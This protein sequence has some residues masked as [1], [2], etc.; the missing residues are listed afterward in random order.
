MAV[1]RGEQSTATVVA[2]GRE[3]LGEQARA[4]DAFGDWQM[5]RIVLA[6]V[7][8]EP[9]ERGRERTGWIAGARQQQ[10]GALVGERLVIGADGR[11]TD[12]APRLDVN[13]LVRED[14]RE[15]GLGIEVCD[16]VDADLDLVADHLTGVAPVEQDIGWLAQR[17]AA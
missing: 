3:L 15:L 10:D 8:V 6:A 11:A 7:V 13:D 9:R 1:E 16:H 2:A 17:A 12:V 4:R 5:I 14:P